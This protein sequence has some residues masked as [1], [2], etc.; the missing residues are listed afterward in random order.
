MTPVLR[1]DEVKGVVSGST[2]DHLGPSAR[3]G[4]AAKALLEW[5]LLKQPAQAASSQL[6]PDTLASKPVHAVDDCT[7]FAIL[8]SDLYIYTAT[9]QAGPVLRG[10]ALLQNSR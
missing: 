5:K 7:V 6:R 2:A 9:L 8:L 3:A 4:W 1:D 10:Q